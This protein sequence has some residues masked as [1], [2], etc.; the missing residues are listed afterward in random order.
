M[1][2]H[3][4]LGIPLFL[5]VNTRVAGLIVLAFIVSYAIC[6]NSLAG[7]QGAWFSELFDA[8]TRTSGHR[9]PTSSQR[10]SPVSPRCWPPPSSAVSAGSARRCCSASTGCWA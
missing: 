10:S 9:C 3:G 7:V 2:G 5:T 6:Q 8:K 1:R 4:G